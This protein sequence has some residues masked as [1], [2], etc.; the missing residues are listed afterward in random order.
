LGVLGAGSIGTAG[1]LSGAA[2]PAI[3]GT[4]AIGAGLYG[5]GKAVA[6]PMT[7]KAIGTGLNVAGKTLSGVGSLA[8]SGVMPNA[9]GAG[10][11][12]GNAMQ[13]EAFTPQEN[14]LSKYMSDPEIQSILNES[15]P[16]GDI[17][18]YLNDPE[19]QNILN[20]PDDDH[21]TARATNSV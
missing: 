20:E 2:L 1:W 16:Q 11:I 9:I 6:S 19:I 12:A 4:A 8:P 10:A 15:E 7:R 3:A 13:N 5:A 17:Q 18:K 14:D 21:K